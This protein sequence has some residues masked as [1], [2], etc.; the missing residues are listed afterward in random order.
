MFKSTDVQPNH[1]PYRFASGRQ[2]CFWRSISILKVNI[3]LN[4]SPLLVN[5]HVIPGSGDMP[6][7]SSDD[8]TLKELDGGILAESSLRILSVALFSIIGKFLKLKHIIN[9]HSYDLSRWILIRNHFGNCHFGS[10]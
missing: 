7:S 9:Y 3:I 5:G 8:H 10:L 1:Q 6:E 2:A 4:A